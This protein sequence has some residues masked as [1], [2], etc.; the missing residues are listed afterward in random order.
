MFGGRRKTNGGAPAPLLSNTEQ[1]TC[2]IASLVYVV[3][4]II[5]LICLII[6]AFFKTT[7][8][9][10]HTIWFVQIVLG[11][12]F[13]FIFVFMYLGLMPNGTENEFSK[14]IG[15]GVV[16]L[17][18]Q[19]IILAFGIFVFVSLIFYL[20]SEDDECKSESILNITLT[21][22]NLLHSTITTFTSVKLLLKLFT[23]I[24]SQYKKYGK[25]V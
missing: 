13:I 2:Q 22:I 24:A 5:S 25:I 3:T 14:Y 20:L 8:S 1:S 6:P 10:H 12:D 18:I 23:S 16:I 17:A 15:T 7:C 21:S 9:D 4:S 19:C 11:L